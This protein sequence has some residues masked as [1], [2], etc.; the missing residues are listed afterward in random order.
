MWVQEKGDVLGSAGNGARRRPHAAECGYTARLLLL[1]LPP[2]GASSP[3]NA[4][5]TPTERRATQTG[6]PAAS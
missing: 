5:P 6:T 1:M 2:A 3:T 4:H